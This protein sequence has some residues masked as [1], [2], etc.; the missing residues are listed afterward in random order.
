VSPCP[1]DDRLALLLEER[2][3]DLERD[4]LETHLQQCGACQ[5]KLEGMVRVGAEGLRPKQ[6][7]DRVPPQFLDAF[8]RS[9]LIPL[10]AGRL[11]DNRA[12]PGPETA[13]AVPGYEILGE[14]GRGGMGV[15][16][17]ARQRALG[18]VVALKMIRAGIDPGPEHLARF[19]TEAEAVARLQ[20]PNIV[21][22]FEVGEA[23]GRPYLV[24]EYVDGG[25]LRQRLAGTP[26][27]ARRVAALVATIASAVEH[28]HNKGV[29]HRDLKPANVLLTADG[30][31]KVTDFGLAKLLAGPGTGHTPSG[32]ILGTPSYMAPE[33]ATGKGKEVGP[34]ADVYALGA[35]LY[36]GLTGRP[37]FTGE[38]D[39]ETLLQVAFEEVLPPGRL[40]PRLPRDLETICLK[41]LDKK[42]ARRYATAGD[43]ADDL[44]R[45]QDGKPIKARPTPFWERGLKAARRRPALTA[46]VAVSVLAAVLLIVVQAVNNRRIT[47]EVAAKTIALGEKDDALTAARTEKANAEKALA[48]QRRTAY[49]Q[50]VALAHR[51]LLANQVDEADELLD[52]CPPDLRG[53]EWYYLKRQCHQD[54]LTFAVGATAWLSPDGQR[55]VLLDT[56]QRVTVR[57][58]KDRTSRVFEGGLLPWRSGLPAVAFSPDG[59]LLAGETLNRE[60]KVLSATTGE[61]VA[62]L[63]GNAS[64]INAVAFSPDGRRIASAGQDHTVRVWDIPTRKEAFALPDFG[65]IN[66]VAFSPDG[67][68]LVTT[69][70]LLGHVM[71]WDASTGKEI[72][73]LSGH[74]NAVNRVVFSPDG[75][76]LASADLDGTVK[77]WSAA[78]GHRFTWRGQGRGVKGLAFS[79]DGGRLAAGGL[80]HAIR[81]WDTVSGRGLRTLHGHND[82]VASVAFTDDGTRL[83]S[84]S[85]D[86]TVKVWDV[87]RDPEVLPGRP[88]LAFLAN[89]MMLSYEG[90]NRVAVRDAH[91]GVEV[92]ALD[93]GGPAVRLTATPDGRLFGLALADRNLKLCDARTGQ[94]FVLAGGHSGVTPALAFSPD[95]R[96]FAATTAANVVKLWET[97]TGRELFSLP[98]SARLTMRPA[99]LAFSPD[100]TRLAATTF[101]AVPVWDT[102][103]GQ[104]TVTLQGHT[105]SDVQAVTFDAR[106]ERLATAD[107]EG[108]VK[109]W[110]AA[111]GQ[112][113]VRMRGR[114]PGAGLPGGSITEQFL[115][116]SPDGQRLAAADVDL[117][118]V[119]DTL[120]GQEALTIQPHFEGGFLAGMT[121]DPDG[122]RLF[123][124]ASSTVKVWDATPCQESMT[125]RGHGGFVWSVACSPDGKQVASGSN[126]GTVKLWEVSTGE[127]VRTLRGHVGA[128]SSVAFSPDGR[129]LASGCVDRTV[130]LWDLGCGQP[131][132]SLVGQAQDDS[133]GFFRQ[134]GLA[135][136]PE[137]HR[138]ARVGPDGNVE[139]WDTVDGKE[140]HRFRA[141]DGK[142]GP[143]TWALAW[144]PDGQQ[145]ATAGMEGLAVFQQTGEKV[146][147]IS[148]QFVY[149]INVVF[150]PDGRRL[151]SADQSVPPGSPWQPAAAKIWDLTTGTEVCA[152]KH[153]VRVTCVA[154]SP[155]GRR[156]ASGD[157]EGTIKLWNTATGQ[158]LRTAREH[159]GPV[160]SLAFTPHGRN[161]VSGGNDR[162]VRIWPLSE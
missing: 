149:G 155:D 141:G 25:S 128:L 3:D 59:R 88:V 137:G 21:Q 108:A 50:R 86:R 97:T 136:S 49:F 2:L 33:Q 107:A 115:A 103:T 8:N 145:L 162:T 102:R 116:F 13:A 23:D 113:L 64:Y 26:L 78:G 138:L 89:R 98:T 140:I 99:G 119:W 79:R 6:A 120:S 38:T 27:P 42:P 146:R 153:G 47:A 125:L 104:A 122:R 156:L 54:L 85:A 60:V 61:P 152:C 48:Q 147:T 36:E 154:F 81:V 43:L 93:R 52:G 160:H 20:H 66:D 46:L 109:V 19:R 62:T 75:L 83:I 123:T 117:L 53:W 74:T 159:L 57:D 31:P 110:D 112:E 87:T 22:I 51:Q 130:K 70:R 35:I 28:A 158:E 161:L 29:V 72:R 80:D 40:Q 12:H 69:G 148:G 9:G 10:L 91:T 157:E 14:L 30:T 67:K 77:I 139:I 16:Y 17:Q 126:D 106:G 144:S 151:A 45:F 94:A 41:C 32:A 55:L 95:G 15:V 114:G 135:F 63:P 134:V 121:F 76:Q 18:R 90:P 118:K 143:K 65:V 129:R 131:L 24:L 111:G 92:G 58:V 1:P 142:P 73:T 4:A 82:V 7:R 150:S 37:P 68:T 84:T 5:E 56:G 96:F 71:L 39:V 34:A 124:A 132:L 133:G 44:G 105:G 11:G 100:G 101:G 127:E